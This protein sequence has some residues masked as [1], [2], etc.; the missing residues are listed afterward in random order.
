MGVKVGASEV[1]VYLGSEK[2]AGLGG[3]VTLESVSVE[4][5]ASHYASIYFDVRGINSI[6]VTAGTLPS[7]TTLHIAGD[8]NL[9]FDDDARNSIAGTDIT[10][11]TSGA[12]SN[13]NVQAFDYVC[14]V[15]IASAAQNPRYLA[16]GSCTVSGAQCV[17]VR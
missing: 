7:G 13:V 17:K 11:I 15:F 14:I 2:L 1:G 6:D 3:G 9:T 10:T 12:T 8:D 16:T 5:Q 4:K